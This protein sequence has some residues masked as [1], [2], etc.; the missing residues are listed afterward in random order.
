VNDVVVPRLVGLMR[1]GTATD[2][3]KLPGS[4]LTVEP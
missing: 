3:T 2:P 4:P 1:T